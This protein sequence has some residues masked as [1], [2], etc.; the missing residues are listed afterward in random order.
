MQIAKH[1]VVSIDYT[2]TDDDGTVLDS[3]TG[4]EPLSYLH[5]VGGIIPGLEKALE[6][7]T[8]GDELKVVVEPG[9]AY[10]ELH[11]GLR[12]EV[13][14]DHFDEIESLELGMQFRVPTDQ[15]DLHTVTVVEIT[16]E[17]V[18]VDG[19][20]PLA[21]VT[22]HFEIAIR[23]VRDATEAEVSQGHVGDSDSEDL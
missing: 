19:N 7:Q 23:D 4:Q 10:G 13:S 1:K 15:D 18:T 5:G 22:L 14:R 6:G 3:S 16:D 17:T 2:L 20:H 21:G 12:S 9:D 8:T 11:E